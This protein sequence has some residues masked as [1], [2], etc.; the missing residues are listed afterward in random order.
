[1]IVN[2]RRHLRDQLDELRAA[3]APDDDIVLSATKWDWRTFAHQAKRHWKQDAWPEQKPIGVWYACGSSWIDFVLRKQRSVNRLR[4]DAEAFERDGLEEVFAIK[5]YVYRVKLDKSRFMVIRDE[6]TFDDFTEW[7]GQTKHSRLR[8]MY[9]WA[10]R[11]DAV[12][13]DWDGIEICPLIRSRHKRIWN[14]SNPRVFGWYHGW[15]V[16]SGCVWEPD[17]VLGVT[18]VKI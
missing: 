13:E 4:R 2:P 11:W 8:P 5:Q 12:A 14:E 10:I 7:Y 6:Q 3:I 15:D 16:P 17:S 9:R 1:M 18:E